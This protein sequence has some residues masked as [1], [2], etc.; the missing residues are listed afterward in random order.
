MAPK[1]KLY[2]ATFEGKHLNQGANQWTETV[3]LHSMSVRRHIK[4]AGGDMVEAL[5][6]MASRIAYN[7]GE[8]TMI[9]T[10]TAGIDKYQ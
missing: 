4:A 8:N 1:P 2:A 9:Y 10:L 5:K 6:T 3:G 7:R